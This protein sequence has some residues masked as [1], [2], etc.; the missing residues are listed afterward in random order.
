[1]DPGTRASTTEVGVSVLLFLLLDFLLFRHLF[2]LL[3]LV[4][5]VIQLLPSVSQ[6]VTHDTDGFLRTFPIEL[7]TST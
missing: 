2:S 6:L 5:L 1:M 4:F 7:E 3:L